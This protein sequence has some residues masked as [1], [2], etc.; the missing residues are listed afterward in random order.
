MNPKK[1]T[2][3]IIGGSIA[4][5]FAAR[6]LSEHYEE[7]I[8][9]DRDELPSAPK[10][11]A[12]TPQ[13][14]HPHRILERGKMILDDLFPGY[15]DDLLQHG[16]Y[17]RAGK[18]ASLT[19]EYGCLEM[20]DEDNV[21]CSRA[22]LEYVIRRK[23]QNLSNVQ[24]WTPID[25]KGLIFDPNINAVTGVQLWDRSSEKNSIIQLQ[26]DLV[27]DASG[28]NSKLAGWLETL[29]FT[30]PEAERLHVSL[31]YSTRHYKIPPHIT[32]RWSVILNEGDPSREIGTA[33]FSPIENDV[34]EVVLYRAGGEP[35]PTTN[36]NLY[37][38]KAAE[39]F[40]E[41]IGNLLQELEPLADPRGFRVEMC[42][43][44]HYEQMEQWPSGL[45]V[46][47]DAFCNFDPIFGQGMTVAAIQAETLNKCLSERVDGL[48]PEIGF[49]R[50]VLRKIQTAIEPAWWLS[51]VA[52]LRWPGV[53][54]EGP[55][56]A[57][58]FS[59]AHKIFDICMEQAYGQQNMTVF[60]QYMMVTGL[61]N[62]PYD[63]FNTEQIETI[64]AMDESGDSR[65]WMDQILI[66][67]DKSLQ[68]MLEE[69]I[70]S[71]D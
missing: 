42:T 31:G 49:E 67:E 29:G 7:V 61:I 47:G 14:Y 59:F 66:D 34:A 27:V 30:V 28:R 46:L 48:F 71:F 5:L 23:V 68:Q 44:Q 41:T 56:S 45:L 15:T 13:S 9:T 60:E 21:G 16:A 53:K 24:C 8:I 18:I 10:N 22:L 55:H 33:V 57:K 19:N 11:R 65:R 37:E 17:P 26:A 39:L 51:T 1:G 43:R 70:P 64:I 25:A 58:G 12:G 3:V 63:L 62:S 35:Y 38:R 2:A 32:D 69:I 54:Y 6:V 4:G 50:S 20:P 36:G 40:G 52:D